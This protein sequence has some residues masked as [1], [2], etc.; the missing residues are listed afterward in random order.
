MERAAPSYHVV[1]I[2]IDVY[3]G[4]VPR[5]TGC[6]NDIDEIQ[7][8]LLERLHV[9]KNRIKRFAAPLRDGTPR[10]KEVPTKA[11][12]QANLIAALTALGDAVKPGDRVFIYH[13]GH[14]TR[15]E[16]I[17]PVDNSR[18]YR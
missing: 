10:P 6:V 17:N 11:P 8:V 15:G 4:G 9:P 16:V 14:G 3:S 12:T 2:G 1:L 18:S 5:L 13:S 7:K